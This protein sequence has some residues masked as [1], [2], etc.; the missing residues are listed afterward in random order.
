MNTS[1]LIDT[2]ARRYAR[3]CWWADLDDLKQVGHL[4]ALRA[5][6]TYDPRVGVDPEQYAWRA[7]VLSMKRALWAD[8]SPCSGGKHRPN[9][10]LAGVRRAD[11]ESLSEMAADERPDVAAE[12]GEW[13]GLVRSRLTELAEELHLEGALEVLLDEQTA[14][15]QAAFFGVEAR[16]MYSRTKRLRAAVGRDAD[17]YDLMK[18][19]TA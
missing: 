11:V 10:A 2:A 12:V 3:R 6:V 13:A 17:L 18:D 5:A 4:A 7:I 1:F 9:D 14:C 8:S 19:R 15:A 16:V